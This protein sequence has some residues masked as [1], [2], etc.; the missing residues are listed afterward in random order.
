M[1]KGNVGFGFEIDIGMV[2][3]YILRAFEIC[4]AHAVDELS[5]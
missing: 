4:G 3:G 1:N 2:K 5:E